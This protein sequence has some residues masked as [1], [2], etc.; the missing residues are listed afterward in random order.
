[1]SF[2]LRARYVAVVAL[3]LGVIGCGGD[4]DAP[5]S[6]P[7][8]L[9]AA[10]DSSGRLFGAALQSTY[11][12]SDKVYAEVAGTEFGYMTPEWEMKWEATE[13]Y[14]GRF[15]FSAPDALVDFAEKHEL[16]IKGHTLVWHYSLPS[17]V[18]ELETAEDLRAAMLN[19]I[20]TV[21][22]HY[23]GKVVAWDVVNE[24]FDDHDPSGYRHTV[25]YDQLGEGFIDEAFVAAHEADPD[26]LLFYNDYDLERSPSKLDATVTLVE[27]LLDAGV[28]LDGVGI[29]MHAAAEGDPTPESLA[30]TLARFTDLGLLVNFSELDVRVGTVAGDLATKLEVQRARYHDLV[31]VCVANPRCQ[32]I[33][34][35]GVTD[36]HTW[37]D[38]Q[39]QWTWAGDGPHYPLLFDAD[40][41][42]KPAYD[43]AFAAL[44]GR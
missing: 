40:G 5:P 36:A 14:P 3:V 27:R 1:M 15:D 32:S 26:A 20:Q 44:L 21:V 13:P 10:A 17:W 22:A 12:V 38:D 4:D 11:L 24:V 41:S 33:T 25:F 29:Q 31:A 19:H 2:L 16:K 42:K 6:P 39:S 23:A 34:T 8:T 43:G 7:G 28:P 37:L 35:W 9:R 30:E 18:S